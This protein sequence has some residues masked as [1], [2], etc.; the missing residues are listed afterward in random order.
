MR[1][2]LLLVFV[3]FILIL[4]VGAKTYNPLESKTI[5]KFEDGDSSKTVKDNDEFYINVP[6]GVNLVNAS[7]IIDIKDDNADDVEIGIEGKSVFDGSLS[8]EVVV[9]FTNKVDTDDCNRICRWKVEINSDEDFKIK[10]LFINYTYATTPLFNK[11]MKDEIKWASG[12]KTDVFDLSDYFYGDVDEYKY[13]KDDLDGVEIKIDSSDKVSFTAEAGWEGSGYVTFIADDDDDTAESNKI[14]LIVGSGEERSLQFSPSNSSVVLKKGGSQTFGV[15]GSG[16]FTVD[17]YINEKL[18]KSNSLSYTYSANT[19]G[20]FNVEARI[21]STKHVWSISVL[22]PSI[23]EPELL[24]EPEEAVCGN[25]IREEGEDCSNCASDVKCVGKAKCVNG[26]CVIQKSD[27]G[28]IL[29]IVIFGVII[30]LVVVGVILIKKNKLY[31]NNIFKRKKKIIKEFKKP[32]KDLTALKSYLLDNIKKGHKKENLVNAALKQGWSKEDIDKVLK[33]Q[34]IPVRKGALQKELEPLKNYIK[35]GI[36]KGYK[37]NDLV[38]AAMK[39]GWKK[40]QI[41]EVLK[42]I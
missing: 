13:E 17:W 36:R 28:W 26:K 1:W 11:Y 4:N 8:K 16:T 38:N 20:I 32:E 6:V 41:D 42:E 19:V 29:W 23:V 30:G 22:E 5:T 27:F 34:A 7:F 9:V 25:G 35:D 3:V 39:I 24:E 14:K 15:S 31:F 12:S 33:E 37:R 2:K 40:E 21:G 18:D 10:D